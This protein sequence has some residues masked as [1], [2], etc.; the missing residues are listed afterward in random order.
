M[1]VITVDYDSV[2]RAVRSGTWKK[3]GRFPLR[4][5]LN[6][7]RAVVQ[8]PVGTLSVVVW[9]GGV[10][11]YETTVDDPAVQEMERMAVWDAEH[12]IPPRLKADFGAEEA[13][14]HV[15]GPIWRERRIKE[16]YALRFPEASSHELPA[17]WVPTDVR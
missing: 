13:E 6:S 9:L 14:W 8:W 1:A 3:L 10:P 12:H 16:E 7:P 4:E 11:K 15:G 17:D 2:D 5:P